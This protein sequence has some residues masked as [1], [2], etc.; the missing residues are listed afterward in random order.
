MKQKYISQIDSPNFMY[1]NHTQAE[2]DVNIIHDLI[3]GY[4]I[5]TI[6]GITISNSGSNMIISADYTWELN[7]AEPFI[8]NNGLLNLISVNLQSPDRQFFN[9]WIPVYVLN[10]P[11]TGTTSTGGTMTFT[12]SPDMI[13]QTSFATGNYNLMFNLISRRTITPIAEIGT[14]TGPTPTPT[15]THSPTPTPTHTPGLPTTP[16]PTPSH[17]GGAVSLTMT[18]AFSPDPGYTGYCYLYYSSDGI[19]YELIDS[20]TETGSTAI[21]PTPGG[22][23]YINTTKTGGSGGTGTKYAQSEWLIDLY[24]NVNTGSGPNPQSID[25]DPFQVATSGTHNY[26]LHGYITNLL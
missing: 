13:G 19:T 6:S 15:P 2:Y 10:T 24:S 14:Y 17:T 22:W 21:S 11:T 4:P 1:P 23:Y 20:F 25:S 16:T 7:G 26:V 18:F 3:E 9:N 8:N 12:V 5:G